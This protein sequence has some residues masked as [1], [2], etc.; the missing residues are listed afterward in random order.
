MTTGK[1]PALTPSLNLLFSFQNFSI[2]FGKGMDWIN[3]DSAESTS[4]IYNKKICY[5]VGFGI[6]IFRS[7]SNESTTAREDQ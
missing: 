4:W 7:S 6:N 1:K 3:A 5:A 2:G